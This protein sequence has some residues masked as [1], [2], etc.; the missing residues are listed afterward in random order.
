MHTHMQMQ[1]HTPRLSKSTQACL[2][3]HTKQQH[4]TCQGACTPQAC[5]YHTR[6]LAHSTLTPMA[7][8]LSPIQACTHA[9]QEQTSTD[10]T[11][12]HARHE[13]S[14]SHTQTHTRACTRAPTAHSPE[15]RCGRAHSCQTYGMH[16]RMH[17]S[18]MRVCGEPMHPT[19]ALPEAHMHAHTCSVHQTHNATAYTT[20]LHTAHKPAQCFS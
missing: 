13:L 10:H 18:D 12:M 9:Q 16:A 1:P 8:L 2:R 14:H 11:N 3:A 17:P 4:L 20:S 7:H 19:P 5:T 15:T 6:T